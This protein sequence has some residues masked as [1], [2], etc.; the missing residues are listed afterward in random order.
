MKGLEYHQ[1]ALELAERKGNFSLL[2]MTKNQMVH[3]YR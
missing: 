2:A 3:V 1:K